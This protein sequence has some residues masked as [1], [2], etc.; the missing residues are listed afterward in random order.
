MFYA[1]KQVNKPH[2]IEIHR[3]E[4][5][6]NKNHG[7]HFHV[8]FK[9]LTHRK[10]ETSHHTETVLKDKEEHASVCAVL[11]CG[12]FK[13]RVHMGGD[14][15]CQCVNID[16]DIAPGFPVRRQSAFRRGMFTDSD[17]RGHI[18]IVERII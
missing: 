15:V 9:T 3:N 6:L 16:I 5:T 10:N 18:Q 8:C 17:R 14:N 12:A 2:V 1:R 7:R 11:H 13:T 4:H